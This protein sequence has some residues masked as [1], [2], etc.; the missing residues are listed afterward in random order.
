MWFPTEQKV[1]A[2]FDELSVHYDELDKRLAVYEEEHKAFGKPLDPSGDFGRDLEEIRDLYWMARGSY[3][4][5]SVAL[6]FG[7]ITPRDAA[8]KVAPARLHLSQLQQ[9]IDQFD[10]GAS[11]GREA[12]QQKFGKN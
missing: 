3:S 8:K 1:F 11:A 12:F 9:V 5:A 7:Q 6:T 4:E 10:A 2:A